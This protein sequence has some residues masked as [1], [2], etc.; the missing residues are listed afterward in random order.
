M[1]EPTADATWTVRVAHAGVPVHL[2]DGGF[3]DDEFALLELMILRAAHDSRLS[4][5]DLYLLM[6][7]YWVGRLPTVDWPPQAPTVA[8]HCATAL[9]RRCACELDTFTGSPKKDRRRMAR[10]AIVQHLELTPVRLLS[11]LSAHWPELAHLEVPVDE[12]SSLLAFAEHVLLE[13][14]IAACL[15]L[16]SVLGPPPKDAAGGA[17]SDI[18]TT[19]S[20]DAWSPLEIAERPQAAHAELAR[21][22]WRADAA[23]ASCDDADEM[24]ASARAAALLTY[25]GTGRVAASLVRTS[26]WP[27][28]TRLVVNLADEAV[29]LAVKRLADMDA[30]T[31]NEELV[32]SVQTSIMPPQPTLLEWMRDPSFGTM[33]DP[34]AGA[35]ATGAEMLHQAAY[36]L[37]LSVAR[38]AVNAVSAT[39]RTPPATA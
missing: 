33:T 19:H 34:T 38:E 31:D 39:L 30:Q 12:A 1:T 5:E 37:T 18:P 9:A 27:G 2:L 24:L 20:W 11:V 21:L 3:D 7:R 16:W 32:D 4:D 22:G 26:G 8:R 6:A 23:P 15:L 29:G 14:V 17:I 36:G 13:P 10:N 35:A 28:E 25:G